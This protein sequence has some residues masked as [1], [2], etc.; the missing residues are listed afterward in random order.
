ML[1][2]IT[3]SIYFSLENPEVILEYGS[4]VPIDGVYKDVCDGSIY[5]NKIKGDENSITLIWHIDGAPTLKNF[6]DL[7]NNSCY[8]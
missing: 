3:Q 6:T 5:R 8:C 4:N 7:A 2:I 1:Y